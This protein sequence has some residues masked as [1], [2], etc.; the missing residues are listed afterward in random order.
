MM[1]PRGKKDQKGILGRKQM[2][3]LRVEGAAVKNHATMS[4][5]CFCLEK[6][7]LLLFLIKGLN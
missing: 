7:Y 3:R 5:K 1:G 6:A 4:L 2:E